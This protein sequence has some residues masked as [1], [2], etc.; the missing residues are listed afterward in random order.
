MII[1]GEDSEARPRLNLSTQQW[2]AGSIW[3]LL[4][5]IG[6]L[7]F[8]LLGRDSRKGS[9]NMLRLPFVPIR[10]EPIHLPVVWMRP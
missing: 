10:W 9:N 8:P 7:F 6:T 1:K 3:T 4:W 5:L 2:V